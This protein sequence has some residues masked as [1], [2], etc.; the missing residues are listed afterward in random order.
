MKFVSF[1]IVFL[2]LNACQSKKNSDI[3]ILESKISNQKKLEL[4]FQDE[5]HE[6]LGLNDEDINFLVKIYSERSY[7]P[8]WLSKNKYSEAGIILM[9]EFNQ[10]I[11]YGLPQKRH[12]NIANLSNHEIL[13]EVLL[14]KNLL[15]IVQDLNQGFFIDSLK[16]KKPLSYYHNT[17]ILSQFSKYKLKDSIHLRLID[18]GITDT[19]YQ[20]LAHQLY[21]FT[22]SQPLN[23][24]SFNVPTFKK[25]TL[26]SKLLGIK[27]LKSKQYL[28]NELADSITIIEVLKR[29]Q[30]DNALEEDGKIGQLTADALN[31]TNL[32]RCQR[33]S[34]VLE[35]LRWKKYNYKR[36]VL[37]NIPEYTLR[38]YYDD[39]LRSVHNI[40]VGKEDKQTPEL[41]SSIYRIVALPYWS[42]PFSIAS[43][44]FLPLLKHNPNYLNRNNMKMYRN[45]IEVDPLSVNWKKIKEKTFPFKV[46]QQPGIGNSLGIIKFEFNNKFSVYV[47]DTP[48]KKL[49]KTKVR[50]YS[51]GCIRCEFPDSLG[52]LILIADKNKVLPDSLE[53]ILLKREH[54]YILLNKRIPIVVEYFSVV[55]NENKNIIFLRDIYKRDEKYLK[56]M[57]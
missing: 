6:L 17:A 16:Q 21:Y 13:N 54:H 37:I 47:H 50:T 3:K 2:F 45:E 34:L 55:I 19:N 33:A 44:E 31:E 14:T 23:D 53:N 12:L 20:K 57:F 9:Q 38:F 1:F 26:K 27:A 49:F 11:S 43:E 42:V 30:K 4:L 7:H 36:L 52:K 25:D 51:H 46:I 22:R 48:T 56:K 29:F 8:F 18:F 24:S 35:K 39:T 32:H 41:S 28:Q 15:Q 5:N 10:L 40:I